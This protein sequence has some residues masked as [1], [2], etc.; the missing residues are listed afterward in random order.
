MHR[1][2]VSLSISIGRHGRM[3]IATNPLRVRS[4][5][6]PAFAR[7][8]FSKSPTSNPACTSLGSPDSV[9]A[10]VEMWIPKEFAYFSFETRRAHFGLNFSLDAVPP[11]PHRSSPSTPYRVS[12]NRR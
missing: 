5:A 12:G 1:D 11:R 7:Q 3:R 4:F 6:S 10:S 8:P 2:P 9:D